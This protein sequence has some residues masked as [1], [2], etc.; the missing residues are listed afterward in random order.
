MEARALPGPDGGGERAAT[1]KM[2]KN[3]LYLA[4]LAALALTLPP[5]SR[6]DMRMGVGTGAGVRLSFRTA[7][8]G[9]ALVVIHGGPGYEKALM[10]PGFDALASD[11]KVVYYDQRGCGASEPV[12]PTTPMGIPDHVA[13]LEA[14]RRYLNIPSMSIAAHGWGAL[15]AIG[16]SI[17]YPERVSSL[18]LITPISPFLP[19]PDEQ[20]ILDHLPHEIS[21]EISEIYNHPTISLLEKRERVMKLMLPALFYSEDGLARVDVNALTFSPEANTRATEDLGSLD[22][23]PELGDVSIP[24]LVIVGRHDPLTPVR[25]QMAYADGIRTSSAVVFNNSGHFPFLEEPRLFT[26]VTREFILHGS[27]P[28]LVRAEH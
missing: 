22:V 14:L 9:D 17:E 26:E 4:L 19:E 28:K 24:T 25:D 13:D 23:F 21:D 15:I 18:M 5:C 10:Y 8:R 11:L 16:Y 27:L 3:P 2:T 12:S 20:G 7:G 6:M 1:I